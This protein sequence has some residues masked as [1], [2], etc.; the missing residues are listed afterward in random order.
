MPKS[1]DHP[2][3]PD[4]YMF[5]TNLT[6]EDDDSTGWHK[7]FREIGFISKRFGTD[8]VVQGVRY[9]FKPDQLGAIGTLKF[10]LEVDI[11]P[12]HGPHTPGLACARRWRKDPYP[13]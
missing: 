12:V 3:L 7:R 10:G 2:E 6:Y 13:T 11:L 9:R 4:G 5:L 1:E 8:I